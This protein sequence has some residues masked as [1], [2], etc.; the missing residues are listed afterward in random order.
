[1][2]TQSV[3]SAKTNAP[4]ISIGDLFKNSFEL[5]KK[6]AWKY[7]GITLIPLLFF[8]L[9]ALVGLIGVGAYN[10]VPGDTAK[11]A[12]AILGLAYA[13]TA[14]I[15]LIF[16]AVISQAAT[17]LMLKDYEGGGVKKI[18]DYMKEARPLAARFFWVGFLTSLILMLFFLLFI[19]PGIIFAIYYAFANW[20]LIDEGKTGYSALKRSKELV[21][22]YWWKLFFRFLALGSIYLIISLPMFFLEEGTPLYIAGNIIYNI[23]AFVMA[24]FIAAYVYYIYLDLKRIKSS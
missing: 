20:I 5:Y 9:A 22:S 2:E 15:I 17:Y 14:I 23:L 13:I 1:M 4:L 10:I 24:P 3:P 8:V 11:N 18:W 7:I 6:L 19:V 16:L 21:K 12:I